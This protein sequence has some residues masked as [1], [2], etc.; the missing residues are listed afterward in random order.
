MPG[1]SRTLSNASGVSNHIFYRS[2]TGDIGCAKEDLQ[3][4]LPI[5]SAVITLNL[6]T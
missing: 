2:V 1:S 4:Y 3:D 5:L 6:N